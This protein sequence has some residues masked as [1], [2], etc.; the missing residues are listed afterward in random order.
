MYQHQ[1]FGYKEK[2]KFPIY[3]SKRKEDYVLTMFLLKK[4]FNTFIVMKNIFVI[5]A[6]ILESNVNDC[7]EINGKQM[8][9]MNLKV[10]ETNYFLTGA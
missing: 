1:C 2:E 3:V 6:Q 7:F 9:K 10:I 5:I 4:S 8:I